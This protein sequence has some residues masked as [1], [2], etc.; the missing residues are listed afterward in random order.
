MHYYSLLDMHFLKK[1]VY[2]DI[3][4][5]RKG[6]GGGVQLLFQSTLRPQNLKVVDSKKHRY[7]N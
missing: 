3:K 2:S 1:F 7:G 6:R 5:T 4:K